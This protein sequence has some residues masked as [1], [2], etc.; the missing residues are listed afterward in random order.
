VLGFLF[1]L[2][3]CK[4]KGER[5]EAILSDILGA[6]KRRAI[7]R[8]VLTLLK[9]KMKFSQRMKLSCSDFSVLCSS[10][11]SRVAGHHSEG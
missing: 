10:G 2:S 7:W 9:F 8:Y 1:H 11:K 6:G 5:D 3:L 4:E